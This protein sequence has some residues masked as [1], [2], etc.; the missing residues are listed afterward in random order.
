M[1][2]S[3]KPVILVID[4]EPLLLRA[5]LRMLGPSYDVLAYEQAGAGL[6]YLADGAP[7][8]AILCDVR[9]GDMTGMVFYERLI[10]IRPELAARVIFMTGSDATPESAAFLQEHRER[11][12]LKPFQMEELIALLDTLCA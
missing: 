7:C 1:S 12:L 10:T 4:D 3:H 5:I 11:V 2:E 9:L 8:D 6:A